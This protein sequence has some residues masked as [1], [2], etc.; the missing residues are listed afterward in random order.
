MLLKSRQRDEKLRKLQSE[1][2]SQSEALMLV[3]SMTFTDWAD[4]GSLVSDSPVDTSTSC[5]TGG[6]S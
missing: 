1:G 2:K 6:D 4:A 3:E 5:D